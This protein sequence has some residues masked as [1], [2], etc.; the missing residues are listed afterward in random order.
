MV[1]FFKIIYWLFNTLFQCF[2]KIPVIYEHI[3]L[4]LH[5]VNK[6]HFT[7]HHKITYYIPN[8][9]S[10]PCFS[11]YLLLIK[12]QYWFG[13]DKHSQSSKR[14]KAELIIQS[15][16]SPSFLTTTILNS[17]ENWKTKLYSFSY[18]YKTRPVDVN[19]KQL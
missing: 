13:F 4:I 17:F 6:K 1:F 11:L 15:R 3:S 12:L 9:F 14:I 19:T 5:M 10:L 2:F 18:W 8:H 7:F 16:N